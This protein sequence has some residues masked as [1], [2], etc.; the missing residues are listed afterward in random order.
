MGV[1]F[2][3]VVSGLHAKPKLFQMPHSD[4][5]PGQ[6]PFSP[7]LLKEN[8][9]FLT[10]GTCISSI[11]ILLFDNRLYS[12]RDVFLL[13]TLVFLTSVV[14]AFVRG[15]KALLSYNKLY[16]FYT[17]SF[18][19]SF[20]FLTLLYVFLL[21]FSV[22]WLLVGKFSVL[23]TAI[24]T[25]LA[26]FIMYQKQYRLN[27]DKEIVIRQSVKQQ[28]VKELEV[29]KQ[30]IDPHFIFNSFNTL[31]FLIDEN[32]EKAKQF[33]NKLAN[34]HR[35]ILFNSNK[36]LVSVADEIGFAKDY[37]YLQE[38][39][40]S[41]E[42]QIQFSHFNEIDNVFILPVSIQILIENAIKHNVFTPAN[43]LLITVRYENGSVTVEN[44]LKAKNY[45]AP[46]SK[47]GLSN[48]RDRCRLILGKELRIIKKDDS[49]K[50]V[51]P[52]LN[53]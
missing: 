3:S 16:I 30:Q 20:F 53:K 13:F 40:Y 14:Q 24:E 23:I 47:I 7:Y 35:Y 31:A 43:P 2:P 34:V 33:S 50:V 39:R 29:L 32:Q 51:L 42:V 28:Q 48:L 25:S 10:V 17:L 5:M 27:L 11:S 36:N 4:L 45:E 6:A 44:Q 41:N 15:I 18:I 22:N 46:S 37:A 38:M 21:P 49:F 26:F 1:F 8:I 19:T 9:F 52:L 12:I